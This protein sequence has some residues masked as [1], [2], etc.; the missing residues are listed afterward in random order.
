[1]WGHERKK[2][3]GRSTVFCAIWVS[4]SSSSSSIRGKRGEGGEEE[5]GEAALLLVVGY[6]WVGARTAAGG[7][8][9]IGK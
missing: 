5:E 8:F 6:V 3:K 9:S 4:I 2:N 1:V 7:T